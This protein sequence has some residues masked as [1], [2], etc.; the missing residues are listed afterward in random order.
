MES[1]DI[2]NPADI[3]GADRGTK[4]HLAVSS[5]QRALEENSLRK[6]LTTM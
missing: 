4:N 6:Q 2:E 5:G 3:L 1:V